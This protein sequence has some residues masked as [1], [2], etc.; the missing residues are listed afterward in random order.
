MS[1][2][3][4][5]KNF[6]SLIFSDF[7]GR[8]IGMVVTIYIARVLG[9]AVFGRLSFAQVYVNYFLTLTDFGLFTLAIREIAR[10][11]E[12][13]NRIGSNLLYL[14]SFLGA[15]A[16]ILLLISIPLFHFKGEQTA[17]IFLFGL[18]ILPAVLDLSFI[19]SAHQRMEFF[20]VIKVIS[21]LASAF[22]MFVLLLWLQN[23]L[24]LPIVQLATS[25]VAAFL[26]FILAK[27]YFNFHFDQFDLNLAKN[28]IK[29]AI[30]IGLAGLMVQL[31]YNFDTVILQFL[32]GE[33]VV[34]W[35]NVSYKIILLLMSLS[36]FFNG[37]LFPYFSQIYH[38]DPDSL[39]KILSRTARYLG[40]LIFPIA[41]GGV[42][43]G[44][45]LI[46][47]LYGS[48]FLPSVL[49][50]QILILVPLFAYLN[51]LFSNIFIAANRQRDNLVAVICGAAVN[52]GL[53]TLLIPK[54][55]LNGAAVATVLAEVAV[56][57]YFF[58]KLRGWLDFDIWS[59]FSTSLISALL[60]GSTLFLL[61]IKNF[62]LQIALGAAIYFISIW[63]L[64][65]VTPEDRRIAVIFINV[66][67][68]KLKR[69]G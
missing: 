54:F 57:I 32:K 36:G 31:Y 44:P 2:L 56:F 12:L 43:T 64:K 49:A 5:V 13:T 38:Q 10:N 24:V 35:Y 1:S 23:V 69:G 16:L 15:A 60:M 63:I 22:L 7:F 29:A 25:V 52:M 4:L 40:I 34:G 65:G 46:P 53:N 19:F 27:R 17:L 51:G 3:R 61:S 62:P 41:V 47:F 28:L 39:N 55:S 11:Q 66:L 8:V 6:L 37:V 30:P 26:A 42:V 14:R 48:K 21:Q 20:A 18:A 45:L 58:F 68:S 59:L 67:K 33:Q 50:F 9:A